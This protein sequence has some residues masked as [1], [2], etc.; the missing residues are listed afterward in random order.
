M[1]VYNVKKKAYY[2][3]ELFP[4]SFL[5]GWEGWGEG[6]EFFQDLTPSGQE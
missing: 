3:S 4:K 5:W 1:V 6:G 2:T